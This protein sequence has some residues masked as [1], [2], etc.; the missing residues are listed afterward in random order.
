MAGDTAAAATAA[1]RAAGGKAAAA[2]GD[3]AAAVASEKA[4]TGEKVAAGGGVKPAAAGGAASGTDGKRSAAAEEDDEESSSLAGFARRCILLEE[5][6]SDVSDAH[7]DVDGGSDDLATMAAA[8]T[9]ALA[10]AKAADDLLRELVVDIGGMDGAHAAKLH[11]AGVTAGALLRSGKT[12]F[13][14]LAE[15]AGLSIGVRMRLKGAVGRV[16]AAAVSHNVR[17]PQRTHALPSAICHLPQLSSSY[18]SP[19]CHSACRVWPG[20]DR[21]G[22]V[23]SLSSVLVEW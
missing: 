15:R 6:Y 18:L 9:A 2:A 7:A 19:S 10:D 22:H 8:L 12:D 1:V 16:V 11:S 20:T 17:C 3:K 21:C 5:K 14:E 13:D 23:V 4:A